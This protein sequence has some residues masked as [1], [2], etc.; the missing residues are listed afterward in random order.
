MKFLT[1][2]VLK[3][4][5]KS[6]NNYL[7]LNIKKINALNVFPVPD[8]DTGTN[9]SA[10]LDSSI[11]EI[12]SKV[13]KSVDELMNAVAFGSLKGA[14][15]NSGVILSQL[16]RGFAK[17][18]KGKDVLDI[19]TFVA[20]LKSA[21]AS[22]Y[23]AV[24]KPTEGTMLTVARG[25]AEDVEREALSNSISEIEE[26]LE[27]CVLS[28]RKWLSKTPEMLPILKEANVVD[29]GG[30]GLVVIF[31]GMYKFLKEGISFEDV[32]EE[33]VNEVA[34]IKTNEIKFTYCTEFFITGLKRNIED[35][36][37]E[38]LQTIGDSIIVIQDGEILKTHVHTNSP[39]KVI[40]KAL[41]YG[42]L[43]NIKIDNMKY[44]HQ[45]FVKAET[46]QKE[47]ENIE[48]EMI[49]KEYGFVAVSQGE[50]F[51]EILKGL[52][53]DFIIEGGQTMN[54]SAEDFISAI[55]NVPAKNIF[56][57][58]NN[59]NVIMSAELSLQLINTKKNVKIVKTN[60]IPECIAAL[61]RFDINSDVE[62]NI[63]R[64]QEAIDSIKVAEIT[65]AVRDTKIN[66]FEIKEG[67]FIG[68]SKKEIIQSGKD[69]IK[70]ASS[71]AKKI[72]DDSTQILSIY[73]GKNVSSDDVQKLVENL[74]A[75]YPQ[76]DIESY[77]S[78]NDIYHFIIVA[79]M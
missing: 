23:R 73:Y 3:D 29:S 16:L 70:V 21:S 13:F 71:C 49:T 66:G 33:A 75:E 77:E 54:P 42:E 32:Q 44:Q 78:G 34:S 69:L 35:E 41:K 79:E 26:L 74:K 51:N 10:T 20:C 24:M 18:L 25:I 63:Q 55:K 19:P 67:D 40:E 5:L 27:L 57:F 65:Q 62:T 56:V 31:E 36:F 37:K 39:G 68:I 6:T 76:I 22:A 7:K 2:D 9:M 28:G 61:I 59:K 60:N 4:M 15:G 52:G 17:E 46:A 30:M 48:D 8:G 1:A 11:K 58:P 47:D 50:G 14:R 38:Y 12:D 45:E 53:V 64:M 72:V 43:I